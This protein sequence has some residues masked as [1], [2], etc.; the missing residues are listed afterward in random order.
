MFKFTVAEIISGNRA[1]L[2]WDISENFP[3][4]YDNNESG[5]QDSPSED[6]RFEEDNHTL[7]TESGQLYIMLNNTIKSLMK[8]LTITKKTSGKNK[9]KR[10]P[11][12]DS[13]YEAFNAKNISKFFP[14][15]KNND[16]LQK[17]SKACNKRQQWL[18]L[19]YWKYRNKRNYPPVGKHVHDGPEDSKD[20]LV[21]D[22]SYSQSDRLDSVSTSG[23]KYKPDSDGSKLS[24]DKGSI[25]KPRL[26]YFQSV[27]R[28]AV[29][30]P[31]TPKGAILGNPFSCY[32]C[33]KIIYVGKLK[34]WMYES[35]N[36]PVHYPKANIGIENMSMRTY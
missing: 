1:Q 2:T 21:A 16:L 34:A 24:H 27:K 8:L 18:I 31:R 3:V 36:S 7:L 30:I 12:E 6:E 9:F 11:W 4:R 22:S 28:K 23:I 14:Y 29:Q 33:H 17:L 26:S 10:P 32:L 13:S 19:G 20:Y 15:A 25:L 35:L 5:I